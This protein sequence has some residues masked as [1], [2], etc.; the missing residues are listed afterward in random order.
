M[1]CEIVTIGDEI[2][3]GQT[4]DTNS[5][6]MAKQLNSIGVFVE[7]ITS[8]ADTREAILTTLEEVGQRADLVLM[9]GGL[10]PTRDDITKT[11]LCAYF[12]THLVMHHGIRERIEQWF[13]RRGVPVLEVNRKQAE[14]PASCVVLENLRGTAQGMWFEKDGT[15]YVSMP[16]VPYEM[17]GIVENHLLAKIKDRFILPHIEHCTIMTTGIGESLLADR[18]KTWEDG[19]DS[20]GIHIAYLPSPGVVKVRLTASGHD[21]EA[22]R[23]AVRKEKEHF[24]RLAAEYIFGYDDLPLEKAIGDLLKEKGRTL[25]VAESCTGGR[26]ASSLTAFA[27]SS[28]FFWGG[29]VAYENQVKIDVLGVPPHAIETHGAVSEP[30]VLA[31]AEGARK[32]LK[33]DYAL[34]TSGVAGPS[35]GSTEKPVGTV[36]IALSGPNGTSATKHNFGA[37]RERNIIRA[38]RTALNLLRAEILKEQVG[39]V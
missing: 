16:G 37:D 31:M 11:T 17:Q 8:I 15:V 21:R 20:K 24:E 33:T 10:G 4:V 1:H 2:L 19:L 28:S 29:V 7:Q 35:G 9:T 12:D 39:D 25:A 23:T 6:W 26:I 34:A 38:M 13:E 18:V 5:A 22:I 27:G 36:W 32:R 14:L 30:V 3:I